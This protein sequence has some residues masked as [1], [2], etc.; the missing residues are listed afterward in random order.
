MASVEKFV[1]H[2]WHELHLERLASRSSSRTLDSPAMQKLHRRG[3]NADGAER[4]AAAAASRV[5]CRV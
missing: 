3:A 1:A 4:Q 2:R 5:A